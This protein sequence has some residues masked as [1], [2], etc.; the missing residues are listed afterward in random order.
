MDVARIKLNACIR[1]I[2]D[3]NNL[4]TIKLYRDVA[5]SD[6]ESMAINFKILTGVDMN[7]VVV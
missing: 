4:W 5:K 1:Y 2:T 6:M 3:P 7:M